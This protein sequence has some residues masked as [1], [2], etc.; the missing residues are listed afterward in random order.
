MSSFSLAIFFD[1]TPSLLDFAQGPRFQGP[2]SAVFAALSPGPLLAPCQRMSPLVRCSALFLLVAL[3]LGCSSSSK[4]ELFGIVDGG[5]GGDAQVDAVSEPAP[6][7][8][9]D[10]DEEVGE[11][12]FVSTLSGDDDTGNGSKAQP[13]ASIGRGIIGAGDAALSRVVLDQGS[14]QESVTIPDL[15]HALVLEGGWVRT[16]AVWQRDC[17]SEAPKKTQIVGKAMTAAAV[18]VDG[19]SAGSSLVRL[20]VLAPNHGIAPADQSGRSSIAVWVNASQLQL[21]DVEVVAG[22]G[23]TGG[24]ASAAV[25]GGVTACVG[26]T[27][28]ASGAGGVPPGVPGNAGAPGGVSSQGYVPGDGTSGGTGAPGQNGN[29]SAQPPQSATCPQGCAFPGGCGCNPDP[30]VF[31]TAGLGRCGCAGEAGGGGGPGRG[32]GA[33]IGILATGSASVS[34]LRVVI[35]AADGGNGSAGA[36]GGNGGAGA[37]GTAGANATCVTGCGNGGVCGNCGTTAQSTLNGGAPGG[38]GGSGSPGGAGGPGAGG[39]SF[40]VAALAPAQVLLEGSTTSVGVGG[41][42]ATSAGK[43]APDGLAEAVHSP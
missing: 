13:F 24:P 7:P 26:T 9:C 8:P 2:G 3:A 43:T 12:V 14:Y 33:S 42:G 6:P 34:A 30:A 1:P 36:A 10:A 18:F 11:A 29:P 37:P 19:V 39:D 20:S 41:K 28:C 17:S 38:V 23:G 21:T 25:N 4:N 40:A 16:G 32:G 5:A 35:T 22:H 31:V 27:D 15:D